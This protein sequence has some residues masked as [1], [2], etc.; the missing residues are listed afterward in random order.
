MTED[1]ILELLQV[2]ISYDNRNSD[3]Y[4]EAS[5]FDAATIERWTYDDAVQAV[6][7]HFSRSTAWIMPAHVTMA[8]RAKRSGPAPVRELLALPKAPPASE[9][10]RRRLVRGWR[11][12]SRNSG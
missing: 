10:T 8:I 9:E 12:D 3:P 11:S 2:V 7:Q 6:R 1:D 5:W 4:T